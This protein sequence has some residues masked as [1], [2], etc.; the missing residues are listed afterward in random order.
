[1]AATFPIQAP[2]GAVDFIVN[3]FVIHIAVQGSQRLLFVVVFGSSK[4]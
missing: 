2:L 4:T 1:M 3:D